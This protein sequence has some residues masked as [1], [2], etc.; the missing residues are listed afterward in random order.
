[1]Y[2]Y[3]NDNNLIYNNDTCAWTPNSVVGQVVRADHLSR[4]NSFLN[5]SV[6][7]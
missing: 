6:G 7:K 3:I 2:K 1:M 5:R 4:K